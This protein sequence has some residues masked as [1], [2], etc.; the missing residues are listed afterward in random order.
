MNEILILCLII[1]TTCVLLC[2]LDV[3]ATLTG[4]NG[5]RYVDDDFE[6]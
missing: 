2:L 1:G 5:V 6:D 3:I 4:A